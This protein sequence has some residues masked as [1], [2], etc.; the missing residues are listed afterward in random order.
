MVRVPGFVGNA[1]RRAGFVAQKRHDAIICLGA[2]IRGETPHFDYVASEAAKGL[3][4]ARWQPASRS[5]L[6]C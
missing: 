4:Q 1:G 3:A 6:A 2:V 5:R